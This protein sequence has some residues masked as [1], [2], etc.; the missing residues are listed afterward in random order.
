MSFIA[1]WRATSGGGRL[2]RSPQ[3][4]RGYRAPWS[5]GLADLAHLV[6]CEGLSLVVLALHRTLQPEIA[7]GQHVGTLEVEDEEHLDGPA[8]DA[9]HLHQLFDDGFVLHAVPASRLD[10]PTVEARGEVL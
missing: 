8:A 6:A 10:L 4:P 3:V 7:H 1:A 9:F 2:E 5:P